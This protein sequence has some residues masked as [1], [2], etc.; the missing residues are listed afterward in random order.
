MV[1][2]VHDRDLLMGVADTYGG[3]KVYPGLVFYSEDSYNFAL[4]QIREL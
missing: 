2:E 3:Y 1:I 4:D